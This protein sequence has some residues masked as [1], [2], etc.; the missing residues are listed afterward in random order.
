M[1]TGWGW[2]GQCQF[3]RACVYEV[4]CAV[5]RPAPVLYITCNEITPAL[6]LTTGGE[7]A[8]RTGFLALDLQIHPH[9]GSGFVE[10]QS[11]R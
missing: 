8:P 7:G 1:G 11:A 3:V 4:A 10:E 9:V 2:G 6:L 5:A